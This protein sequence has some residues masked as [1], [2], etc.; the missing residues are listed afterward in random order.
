MD[1]AAAM[2]VKVKKMTID[3]LGSYLRK[4]LGFG[5][6]VVDALKGLFEVCEILS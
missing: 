6:K 2:E 5:D 3:G 1:L 4:E